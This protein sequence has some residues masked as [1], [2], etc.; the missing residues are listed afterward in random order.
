MRLAHRHHPN[1][2]TDGVSF[3]RLHPVFV[4]RHLNRW[5][6]DNFQRSLRHQSSSS[7]RHR[8]QTCL[9]LLA[10]KLE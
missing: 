2:S 5:M 1:Q 8:Q 9:Y 10:S 4:P 7:P 3:R 6:S